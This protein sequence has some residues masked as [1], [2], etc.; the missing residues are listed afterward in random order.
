MVTLGTIRANM[1]PTTLV[2][3]GTRHSFNWISKRIIWRIKEADTP[4]LSQ[5]QGAFFALTAKE[6]NCSDVKT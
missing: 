1:A 2:T 5:L 3:E 6:C 4:F